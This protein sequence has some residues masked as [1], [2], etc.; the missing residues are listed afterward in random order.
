MRRLIIAFVLCFQ[1]VQGQKTEQIALKYLLSNLADQKM[2]FQDKQAGFYIDS[3]SVWYSPKVINGR[4]KVFIPH[5]Y[6]SNIGLYYKIVHDKHDIHITT[7]KA[8]KN[9]NGF[10]VSFIITTTYDNKTKLDVALDANNYPIGFIYY[11]K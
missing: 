11:N 2:Q 7:T 8:I 3:N 10:I 4:G 9:P 1:F 5:A 6:K